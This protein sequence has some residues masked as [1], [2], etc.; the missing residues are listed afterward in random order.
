MRRRRRPLVRDDRLHLPVPRWS[1]RRTSRS[2]TRT[3][4]PWSAHWALY[5]C[6]R[7]LRRLGLVGILFLI[8][9]GCAIGP[10]APGAGRASPARPC[11]RATSSSGII[12]AVL[13][14]ASDPRLQGRQRRPARTRPGPRRSPALGALLPAS[15]RR[16]ADRDGQDRR[17][18]D[19]GIVIAL[20]LTMGV[21]WHRFTAFPNIFFKRTRR[22]AAGARRAAADDERAASRST[23]RRPTRRRTSSASPRSRTS[24]GRACSTSPPAPSAAAASRSARRGTP[25]SRSRRSC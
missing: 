23:S 9:S 8:A 16:H 19:L 10:A 2:S 15:R 20:N 4:L 3:S 13:V 14:W 1:S 25:A 12:L 6:H 21:A 24:P 7:A 22:R 17:L 18:D 5:G 11:G